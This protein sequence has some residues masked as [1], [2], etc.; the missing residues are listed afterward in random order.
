MRQAI[1]ARAHL[2]LWECLEGYKSSY[3]KELNQAPH[4]F[5]FT[6]RAHLD[7]ALMTLSRIIRRQKDAFTIWDFLNFVEKNP[8]IFSD[9][10]FSQRMKQKPDYEEYGE[11]RVKSHTL[12][13][14]KD[15]EKDKQKLLSQEQTINNLITLRDKVIAHIDRNFLLTGKVISNEYPLQPQQLEEVIDNIVEILN[16]HS[17]AYNSSIWLEKI[18]GEDDVQ[19]VMDFIRFYIQERKKQIEELKRQARA[20]G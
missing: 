3:L 20:K 16:R 18:P 7:D 19:N 13:T 15:I 2:K 17:Y 6:I 10:A 14:Q 5:T 4:F 1:N 8:E 9:E 12:I 11:Y